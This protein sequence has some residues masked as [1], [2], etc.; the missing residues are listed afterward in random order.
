[1][2]IGI[3]CRAMSQAGGIGEYVR[4]LTKELVQN[5]QDK[6]ALFFADQKSAE[7]FGSAEVEIKVLPFYKHKK[8]LPFIYAQ[9]LVPLFISRAKCEVVLFPANIVPLFWR[10]RSLVVVHDLA[11]YKF[12]ELFPDQLVNL[13]RRL[14][15]PNSLR[16][17]TKIIAVSEHTKADIIGLFGIA[18][19]KISVVY[20]GGDGLKMVQIPPNL[21]FAKGEEKT[22]EVNPSPFLK[23][24]SECNP[25]SIRKGVGYF[26]FIGTIEPR[27]NLVRLIRAYKKFVQAT[28]SNRDLV[29][30]GKSGWKNEAIFSIIKSANQELGSKRIKYLGFVSDEQKIELYQ[31]AYVLVMPSIYEGF[32]LPVAE[33]LQFGLPAILAGNSSLPEVGGLAG[34][35]IDPESENEI[36]RALTRLNGNPAWREELASQAYQRAPQFAWATCAQGVLEAIKSLL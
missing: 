10:G 25:G 1:M 15:V 9:L 2:K 32:G 36:E 33:A 13:D 4:Q 16:Q 6:F 7:E 19:E 28:G 34:V 11:V 23:G 22:N 14:L 26:L 5:K 12:P 17:A 3:D 35:Y 27:K 18:P 8:F 24:D 20:E 29:L 31:K 30:A 21:P